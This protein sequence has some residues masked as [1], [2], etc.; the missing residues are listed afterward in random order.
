MKRYTFAEH[1]QINEKYKYLN[2]LSLLMRVGLI[3]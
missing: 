3:D 2:I 1:K